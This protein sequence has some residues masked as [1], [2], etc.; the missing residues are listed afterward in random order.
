MNKINE[1]KKRL[2]FLALFLFLLIVPN[3]VSSA[4]TI[5]ANAT[6][7]ATVYT[8]TDWML[9]LTVIDPD[10]GDTLTAYT[11]FYVNDSTVGSIINHEVSNNTN[12]NV[13][14]LSSSS[15]GKGDNLTAE[16]WAGNGTENTTHYNTS[17]I[18]VQNSAPTQPSLTN[19]ENESIKT[20]V[21][22]TINWSASTDADSDPR[23]Y[24]V[25][26]SNDTTPS[27]NCS[28]T[29]I[30]KTFTD[31][32]DNET[33]YWYII[34]GDGTENSTD[35]ETRQF[36]INTTI[37]TVTFVSPTPLDGVRQINN[38]IYVNVTATHGTSNID[39]CTLIWNLTHNYSMTKI[40]IG[41]SVSCW[42]NM[43]TTDGINYTYSVTANT[44]DGVEGTTGNRTNLENTKP[45]LNISYP[46]NNS[47]ITET[48]T[49]LNWSSSDSD[50]DSIT[51]Y[52]YGNSTR[53]ST[54]LSLYNGTGLNYSW[55]VDD[56]TY[57]WYVIA[58]DSYE[59]NTSSEYKFNVNISPALSG[60][61]LSSASGYSDTSI[62]IYANCSDTGSNVSSINVSIYDPNA[63][64]TNY[65]MTLDEGTKYNKTYTP[66]IVGTYNFSFYCSDYYGNI[67]NNETT[68]LQF[69]SSTRP[70][71]PSGGGGGT[72]TVTYEQKSIGTLAAGSSKKIAFLESDTHGITEIE[73]KVKNRVTNAKIKVDTGSLPSGASLPSTKGSVYKYIEITKVDI[74]DNDI[75]NAVIKF[76]VK[77]SWLT[78]KGYGIDAVSLH[79]YYNKKWEILE[80]KRVGFGTD[81]Y[82][83]SA[84][85]SGFST[86]AVTAEKA[87]PAP[88]TEKVTEKVTAKEPE[89]ET[90]EEEPEDISDEKSIFPKLRF[91]L[92]DFK[93]NI[94]WLWTMIIIIAVLAVYFVQKKWN[95]LKISIGMESEAIIAITTNMEKAENLIKEGDIDSAK[96]TYQK[97]LK[98]YNGLPVKEKKWVYKEIQSLYNK[99]KTT[100]G[101]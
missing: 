40:G 89:E 15:F 48:S 38:Y 76:K 71:S 25:Y 14:N 67:A 78:D 47:N 28:T 45:Q 11:Q 83:Y 3:I 55:Q 54:L 101:Q 27:Y 9:N 77:K 61:S 74:T 96:K 44:T 72:P 51:H 62:T 70:S 60:L 34:A 95:V 2:I 20:S 31:L 64:W 99:I 10:L 73:V 18:I 17:T 69:T 6:S 75:E 86:F 56:G 49:Y 7:P 94:N 92:K 66:S 5:T 100:G 13:A 52:V 41:I 29:N 26:F 8:N 21:N 4:P 32:T 98:I 97:V 79:R 19:P 35:S 50:S 43:T 85:S 93:L 37:P 22:V 23:T 65:T 57:Y 63:V 36:T 39:N 53:N 1:M 30:S 46:G 88:T 59:T 81:Y 87:P 91:S 82:Y 80:T 12:T 58:N 24:Y 90:T 42:I 16:F 33:Y 84:E 68:G